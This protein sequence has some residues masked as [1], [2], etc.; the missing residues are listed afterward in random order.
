MTRDQ[1]AKLG[2]EAI[3]EIGHQI[4]GQGVVV[5][6]VAGLQPVEQI[7]LGIGQEDRQ[8]RAR[9]ARPGG[10]PGGHFLFIRQPFQAPVKLQRAALQGADKGL[11]IVQSGGGGIGHQGQRLGLVI[12][13][14]Q[15]QV[16]DFVG[17]VGEQTVALDGG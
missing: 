1:I 4:I 5:G 2:V 14:A 8:F 11:V 9:Q 13:V 16:G 15:Y 7:H 17:H 12:V 6:Q 3:R 10:A